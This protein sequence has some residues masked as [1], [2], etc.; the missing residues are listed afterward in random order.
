MF[1]T[2]ND[3]VAVL[4]WNRRD[5]NK[6]TDGRRHTFIIIALTVSN[7]STNIHI[8]TLS[9]IKNTQNSYENKT[10]DSM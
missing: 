2:M 4:W 8:S 7:S 5:G 1:I 6:L 9:T 3:I 10:T